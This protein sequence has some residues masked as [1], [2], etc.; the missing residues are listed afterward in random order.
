MTGL[1][2]KRMWLTLGVL[3]GCI[4][5]GCQWGMIRRDSPPLALCALRE[6]SGQ[7]APAANTA[8]P[9]AA[10][11]SP[12][13]SS[14]AS[15]KDAPSAPSRTCYEDTLSGG[16]VFA[17]YCGACHNARALGERPFASYQN[18]A[19]HMRV[20]ANLTGE[21]YRKLM[22]FLRYWHDIP[23]QTP[24]IEPSPK[25]FIF[26]QPLSELRPQK[27]TAPKQEVLPSPKPQQE[28]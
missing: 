6:E 17:M 22:V 9:D 25:R 16:R 4:T 14:I 13:D 21:E 27:P 24:P 26:S 12:D 18:A 10:M 8:V 7:A 1:T 28:K 2:R 15:C 3:S 11:V 23:A 19:N 20:R 5:L